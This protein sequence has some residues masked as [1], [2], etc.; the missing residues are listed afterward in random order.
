LSI[1]INQPH[2]WIFLVL[3]AASIASVVWFY[4]RV[5]P[6]VGPGLRLTLAILRS[7]AFALLFLALLEPVIALTRVISERPVIAVLLDGSRS[8]AIADGTGGARRGDEAL[9][10]LNEIVLPRVAREGELH[11]YAFS[12]GLAPLDVERGTIDGP[13]PKDGESTDIAK[14]FAALG[15][16]FSGRNLGAVVVASDGANNRGVSP[17]EAALALDVPIY[18]LGVGRSEPQADIAVREVV[19]N[20]ISYA[21]EVLPIQ[22]R[23]SSAGYGGSETTL[24]L[25]EDGE[26]LDSSPIRLSDTGE[27]IEVTFKVVPA[28]PGVHRYTVSVPQ[29]P[30]ELTTTNNARVVATNAFKGKIRVLLVATRPSWDFAFVRREFEADE[31]VDLTAVVVKEGAVVPHGRGLP[32][33]REELFTFDLVVLVEASWGRPLVPAEWLAGFV[34]ERGGGLLMVGLPDSAPPEPFS[35][36][37]PVVTGGRRTSTREVRV[38]LTESGESEPTT[39]VVGDRRTN[40]EVWR[41]LPPVWTGERPWWSARADA[42]TLAVGRGPAGDEIPVVIAWRAGAGNAMVVAAEGIWR[43]KLA[44]PDDVDVYDRFLANAARWLTARGELERVVVTTDKDVYAAGEAVH[45]SAQVYREDFRLAGDAEVTVEIARGEGAAPVASVVLTPEGDFYRGR[46]GPLEP[47]RYLVNATGVRGG[48]EMGTADGEFTIEEFS[49]EDSE[50]RKRPALLRRLAEDSGGVYL[51]PETADEMPETIDLDW[52]QRISSREFE[53]WNSPWL[54][55][56]FVG[57]LSVEWTLRRRK[58]LP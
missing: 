39:R 45:L 35:E 7:A 57:L 34:R 42:R 6:T 10:L 3:L 58:G 21:G 46:L 33:S 55:L 25:S 52:T 47:G 26:L 30:G 43:W 20:R 11:A 48:E 32:A 54:L 50:V 1:F 24:E 28:T 18:V 22:V 15:R 31:N 19:T 17:H 40:A 51:S 27:E 44:G 41:S 53:V 5:P 36:A 38:E 8:M 14:A 13:A 56:G 49:L 16:E 9:T 12:S 4:R 29:A 23:V 2:G 37:L